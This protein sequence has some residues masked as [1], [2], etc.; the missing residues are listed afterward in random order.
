MTDILE[1]TF[2]QLAEVQTRQVK[3][4]AAK[5]EAEAAETSFQGI[6]LGRDGS[7]GLGKVRLTNG[8]QIDGQII[9]NK[10]IK[11]GDKVF[12]SRGLGQL[13][14]TIDALN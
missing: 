11:T 9:T 12:Y 7:T 14:G 2:R 4:L 13:I 3:E 5:E 1:L 10:D 8:S 6:F